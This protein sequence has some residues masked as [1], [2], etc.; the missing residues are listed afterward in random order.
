MQLLFRSISHYCLLLP[1]ALLGS[2]RLICVQGTG[3]GQVPGAF[4]AAAYIV[5]NA[6]YL[7][8]LNDIHTYI[9]TPCGGGTNQL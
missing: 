8:L 5:D 4:L 1:P 6:V 7:L 3:L 2:E 9:H